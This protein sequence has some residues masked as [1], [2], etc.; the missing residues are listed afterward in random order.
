[1]TDLQKYTNRIT[2][3]VHLTALTYA[4]HEATLEEVKTGNER[5]LHQ[6]T[7]GD[8]T[9]EKLTESWKIA[10]DDV[11]K[12]VREIQAQAWEDGFTQ[13]AAYY[14]EGNSEPADFTETAQTINPHKEK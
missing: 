10:H 3:L 12:C 14:Y 5:P 9:T 1:M 2:N 4:L 13:G 7:G 8:L 6:A 11:T